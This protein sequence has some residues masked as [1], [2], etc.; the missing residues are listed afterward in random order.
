MRLSVRH[1][2]IAEHS[3]RA[4]VLG[5]LMLATIAGKAQITD[6][7]TVVVETTDIDVADTPSMPTTP[8]IVVES[9][10][11]CDRHRHRNC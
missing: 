5:M 11:G 6:N 2:N 8:S 7:T 4:F 3:A 1:I 10:S 9:V